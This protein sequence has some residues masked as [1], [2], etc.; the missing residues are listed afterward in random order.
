[1]AVSFVVAERREALKVKKRKGALE[2]KAA[3]E[4]N[5][6]RYVRKERKR[7]R[8]VRRGKGRG[9]SELGQ[10]GEKGRGVL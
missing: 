5:P 7:G 6:R 1:V 3:G 9:P 4:K 10:E 8:S 2:T